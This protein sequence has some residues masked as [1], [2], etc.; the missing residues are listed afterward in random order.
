MSNKYFRN[1]RN[2]EEANAMPTGHYL[3]VEKRRDG[4]INLTECKRNSIFDVMLI[5]GHF[6]DTIDHVQLFEKSAGVE[7]DLDCNKQKQE[8][9]AIMLKIVNWYPELRAMY[10]YEEEV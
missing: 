10:F 4:T 2:M 8:G 3:F 6:P 5:A 7:F 9:D 1:I